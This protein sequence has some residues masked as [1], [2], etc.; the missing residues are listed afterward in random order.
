[1]DYG[2]EWE[3]PSNQ[4]VDAPP[5][6]SAWDGGGAST[7]GAGAAAAY[8]AVPSVTTGRYGG[9]APAATKPSTKSYAP[10]VVTSVTITSS[11]RSS[12][13]ITSGLGGGSGGGSGWLDLSDSEESGDEND[14]KQQ[15]HQHEQEIQQRPRILT[16]KASVELSLAGQLRLDHTRWIETQLAELT[17]AESLVGGAS[18][19]QAHVETVLHRACISYCKAKC[20]KTAR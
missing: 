13:S 7:A 4:R 17:K 20:F 3:P 12:R 15:Q 18:G 19:Q 8:A 5:G 6:I 11:G 2:D 14:W 10:A 16:T 9:Y 1:M